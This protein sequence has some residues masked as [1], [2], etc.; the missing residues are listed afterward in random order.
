MKA[1]LRLFPLFLTFLFILPASAA[2]LTRT[3]VHD[4]SVV[5]EPSTHYYWIFGSH[6]AIARSKNLQNWEKR[7]VNWGL[8]NDEG[9]IINSNAANSKAFLKNLTTSITIGGEQKDFGPFDAHAY[10]SA[11]GEDY[12]ID[13]N[14]WAPDVIYNPTMQKWCMYMSLNGP[15]WNSAIVLLTA[16]RI[17][18][19]Y[20]Y[21]GPVV[22]SGFGV[23][24]NYVNYTMT[25]LQ[26]VL[27]ELKSLPAHYNRGGNW[28]NRWP[29][30]I[31]PCVFYDENGQLWMSYGSWSG[32]IWM[33]KLN[34]ENGLRDYDVEY[35][36][37]NVTSDGVT[38]D[39]YFGKK[40]AGGFYSSGEGSYIEHI[41]RYYYLFISNGGLAAGGDANDFNNGGYQMRVFRSIKPDGP[42]LDAN[43]RSA[44]LDAYEL[45]FGPKSVTRGVN[46]F[47]AYTD[48]GNQAVGDFGERSQGHNSIIDAEDG[49]TYL[50]YHTRFQNRGEGHEVRV[51]QVFQNKNGWLCA[52]PFEYTG[53]TMTNEDIA[54]RQLVQTSHMPA[55]YHLLVHRYGLDH[56]KKETVTPVDITL[57]YDGTI[58]G[59][60]TG[61]WQVESGTSYITI[62]LGTTTYFGVVVQQKLEPKDDTAI[63]FTALANNGVSIWGQQVAGTATG[64]CTKDDSTHSPSDNFYDLLGRKWSFGQMKKGIYIQ[65]GRKTVI[66]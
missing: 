59:A 24:I 7:T 42:Y 41:G 39:P 51:H 28:G 33:L 34:A 47:G 30:A 52:A 40:I 58:E 8:C 66:R 2:N 12:S 11:Y 49:R 4:P 38:S 36:S 25:D 16:D 5:W 45:N 10:V 43:N 26:L 31:D 37:T 3:S 64:I 13:G 9:K 20:F 22:Y 35:P 48:W 32:G 44:V 53:E 15:H 46:I 56:R 54:T 23:N 19:P 21:Q 6:R 1:I 63:C 57:K 55:T 17:S 29:H 61:T 18:G 14:L 50:V 27:G 62:K 65:G 60:Y